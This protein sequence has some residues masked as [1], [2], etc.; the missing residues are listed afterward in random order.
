MGL[1]WGSYKARTLVCGA[2]ILSFTALPATSVSAQTHEK[3][4]ESTKVTSSEPPKPRI[5][6][7][8]IDDYANAQELVLE[9]PVASTHSL[10][11]LSRSA[12][13]AEE[14][15]LSVAQ[16]HLGPIAETLGEPGKDGYEP[17]V[18]INSTEVVSA[19]A[20]EQII[21][22][23]VT[24]TVQL[25][26]DEEGISDPSSWTDEHL[27]TLAKLGPDWAI[28]ADEIVPFVA[29][30][31]EEETPD[32]QSFPEEEPISPDLQS[33]DEKPILDIAEPAG[34]VPLG[35]PAAGY[36][37]QNRIDATKFA[38]Y[39]K[40]RTS[41]S[42]A[43]DGKSYKN[44]NYLSYENNCANFAS[45]VLDYSGWYLT[46]GN[47]FQVKNLTK[48]TY[49]LAG[50]AG[51]TRTWTK[52]STLFGFARNTG[53]YRHLSNVWNANTGDLI[54]ADWDPNGRPDGWI[55]HVMVV[56]GRDSNGPRIS[57]K[58][59]NRSNIPFATTA[60]LIK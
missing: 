10:L 18:E 21:S 58:S 38:S 46:G 53:T 26:P 2:I 16:E 27:L 17:K 6:L 5:Q 33:S 14:E 56:S 22:A 51:A 45:Q 39:A 8:A 19:S 43:K 1:F 57:Q 44:G 9:D 13:A 20:S 50:V 24:V 41:G 30:A 59:S 11:R 34:V 48:W 52:A 29:G 25:E 32:D 47:S 37:T 7:E 54:F 12:S 60:K 23:L 55:D 28:T 35:T 36:P 49:N 40:S 3:H 15:T 4:S 31:A 42:Y